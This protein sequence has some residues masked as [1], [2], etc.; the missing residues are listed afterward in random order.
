MKRK[1]K[2]NLLKEIAAGSKTIKAL[3]P[4]IWRTWQQDRNDP[5]LFH[6]GNLTRRKGEVLADE[7]TGRDINNIFLIYTST[8]KITSEDLTLIIT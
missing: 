2:I 6:C 1:E 4:P 3:F 5:E 8:D 7:S